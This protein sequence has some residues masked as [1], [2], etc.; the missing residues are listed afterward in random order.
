MKSQF[1]FS[2]CL[3]WLV[4]FAGYDGTPPTLG[5]PSPS[6]NARITQSLVPSST[7]SPTTSTHS[8]TS[9][10]HQKISA[11]GIGPAKVGM[12]LAQLK[13]V[14]GAQA[15]FTVK[16]SFM[17][18]FDALAVSQS[19]KVQYY[20]LYPAGRTLADTSAIE[21]V[22]TK[23]PDYR[24][25]VG[26]GPG[27]PL[28][29]AAAVYGKATLF[30]N[31]ENESRELVKFAHQPARNISFRP[32]ASG[33]Q[34]AGVYSSTQSEFNKTTTYHDNASIDSVLVTCQGH[35]TKP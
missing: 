5:T 3:I 13:R 14:L 35:C 21:A 26:V 23:N 12:T 32:V 11:D 30:Y 31:T 7:I 28:K 18:D 25:T 24:T 2:G 17:V 34:F 22:L 4:A 33:H 16:S 10:E 15:E 6:D 9:S 29:Q 19:G 20:I 8:L 1:F 27:T